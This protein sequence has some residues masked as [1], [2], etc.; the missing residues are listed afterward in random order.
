MQADDAKGVGKEVAFAE[1][2]GGGGDVGE[3]VEVDGCCGGEIF[4]FD[5]GVGEGLAEGVELG[6]GEG[7]E[8]CAGEGFFP[9]VGAAV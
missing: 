9:E 7:N 2:T 1:E 6:L 4:R 5:E 3:V 8:G